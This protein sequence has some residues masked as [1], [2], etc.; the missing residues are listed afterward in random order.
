MKQC[1]VAAHGQA[2]DKPILCLCGDREIVFHELR[3]LFVEEV[4]EVLPIGC[5]LIGLVVAGKGHNGDAVLLGVPFH[6]GV[7][8]PCLIIVAVSM[9]Q[10]QHREF[11]R[12]GVGMGI[13]HI[14]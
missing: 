9:E 3:Q 4:V 7:A 12:Q 8:Q 5:I 11:P 13:P 1:P 10:I 2:A 14:A 6:A